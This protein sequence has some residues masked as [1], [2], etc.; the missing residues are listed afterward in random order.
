MKVSY[1]F[2]SPTQ[3]QVCVTQQRVPDQEYGGRVVAFIVEPIQGEAG[4]V[5]PDDGYLQ[6]CKD[7]CHANGAL[8][9]ADEVL[10]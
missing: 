8:F 9:V 2:P 6:Q 10:L 5:T 1:S 7:I 3:L 4:V